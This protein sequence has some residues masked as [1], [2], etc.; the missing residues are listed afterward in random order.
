[1]GPRNKPRLE[2]AIYATR[3]PGTYAYALFES[4]KSTKKLISNST[5]KHRVHNS[6]TFTIEG[7]NPVTPWR[8]ERVAVDDVRAEDDILV[9]VIVGKVW[10][11]ATLKMF[12]GMVPVPVDGAGGFSS[13]TWARDV[14]GEVRKWCVGSWEEVEGKALEYVERKKKEGRC[15]VGQ[16]ERGIPLLDLHDGKEIVA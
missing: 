8:Y 5:V 7:L 10:S 3:E 11:T 9:R 6:L 4:P 16:W 12:I 1:M 14:L 2:L 13:R 15:G